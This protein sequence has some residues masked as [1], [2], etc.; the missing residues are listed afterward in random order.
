MKAPNVLL[1]NAVS[2]AQTQTSSAVDSRY[3]A[4][5]SVQF[6]VAGSGNGTV[7]IQGSNDAPSG[8]PSNWTSLDTA[9]SITSAATVLLK[10]SNVSCAWLRVVYTFS[11]GSGTISARLN[12]YGNQ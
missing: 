11:S 6:V 10:Y 2:A 1:L 4:N 3:L 5:F 7:V 9:T 12:G 8:T